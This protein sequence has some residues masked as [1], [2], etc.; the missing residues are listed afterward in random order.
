MNKKAGERVLSIYLFIIYII[1]A[2][3]IVSGVLLFYG[4]SDIR[5]TEASV[6]TDKVIDC[7]VD[8]G[9]LEKEIFNNPFDLMSFC[10]FDFKDN[11]LKYQGEEQYAVQVELYDFE[12][13]LLRGSG[14]IPI[15]GKKDYLEF[16]DL[17][18]KNLPKCNEKSI[19]VLFHRQKYLLKVKSAVGKV[20]KN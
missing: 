2:I 15:V 17:G 10:D 19:Y 5:E 20:E 4:P 1:V 16:C 11:T 14:K 18:G 8:G 13:N 12:K 7:L 3:G 9:E 6:L